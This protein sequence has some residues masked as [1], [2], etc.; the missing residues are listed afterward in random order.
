MK[1]AMLVFHGWNS[2]KAPQTISTHTLT[3]E[4]KFL[5]PLWRSIRFNQ[6]NAFRKVSLKL[7]L[8]IFI[9]KKKDNWLVNS[10]VYERVSLKF[11]KYHFPNGQ[12][13]YSWN[14]KLLMM[15][16]RSSSKVC[17]GTLIR[18]DVFGV[19]LPLQKLK[20]MGLLKIS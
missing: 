7:V 4:L 9:F 1:G 2:G 14:M 19:F 13:W 10:R 15:T 11:Y 20:L 17:Q 6:R 8:T 12:M 5:R 18:S 16:V 3:D